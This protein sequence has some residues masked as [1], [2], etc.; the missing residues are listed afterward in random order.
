[1]KVYLIAN[2]WLCDVFTQGM[3]SQEIVRQVYFYELSTFRTSS[4]IFAHIFGHKTPHF[5]A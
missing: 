1:M 2:N 4:C 3:N 5:G